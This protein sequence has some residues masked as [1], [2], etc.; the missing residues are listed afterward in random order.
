MP[1]VKRKTTTS[2]FRFGYGGYTNGRMLKRRKPTASR[3]RMG[4][5]RR[6]GN[7]GR[8]PP[9]GQELKFKENT[10][11]QSPVSATG[12]IVLSTVNNVAAGTGESER[13]GRRITIK[14]ISIRLEAFL[15]NTTVVTNTDDGVR[16]IVYHDKQCNGAAA[17]VTDILQS[18]TYLAY[19]NLSNKNRFRILADKFID[20]SAQAGAYTGS[21]AAFAT[22]GKTR[23]MY[24]KC[25]M[26]VEFSSTTGAITEIASNNIGILCISSKARLNVNGNVRIRYADS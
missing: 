6:A 26:P 9:L 8:Y 22:V 14:S 12:N 17:A 5:Y 23:S 7:Y 18:A 16:I 4:Y 2:T 1:A 25:N 24:M 3:Y 10:W 19:N 20:I 15:S 13:I 21:A 11:N